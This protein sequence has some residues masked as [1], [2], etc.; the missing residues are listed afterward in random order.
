MSK[1]IRLYFNNFSVNQALSPLPYE[2]KAARKKL[3]KWAL[4]IRPQLLDADY[5]RPKKFPIMVYVKYFSTKDSFEINDYL[6]KTYQLLKLLEQTA[7]IQSINN[8]CVCGIGYDVEIVK[9]ANDE[10]CEISFIT[11][12]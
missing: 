7:V 1:P 8:Q 5:C 12:D 6:I 2:Q 10:G 11:K 4:D 3:L 9:R